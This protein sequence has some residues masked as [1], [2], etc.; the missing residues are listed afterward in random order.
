MQG[1]PVE[2]NDQLPPLLQQLNAEILE[3]GMRPAV[4]VEYDRIP[5]VYPLGNVRITFDTNVSSSHFTN[6]FLEPQYPKRPVMPAGQHLMEVKY[7]A[8]LPDF[9]Y[10]ALQ[11]DNL[12]QTA[13]SKY[14]LCRK[15]SL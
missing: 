8:F 3:H 11:L 2:G 10:H 1:L 9:I 7:D 15:Y 5:Y 14:Y 13:Y 12:Q 4:I 6:Q